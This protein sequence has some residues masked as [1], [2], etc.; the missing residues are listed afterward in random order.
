AHQGPGDHHAK[1]AVEQ[2]CH[3]RQAKGDAIGGQRFRLGGQ[4]PKL[5]GPHGERLEGHGTEGEKQHQDQVD[6]GDAPRPAHTQPAR[7][8]RAFGWAGE[9]HGKG[10]GGN[11]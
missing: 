11:H 6:P 2:G 3:Q 5:P 7:P 10:R 8:K 9:G 1:H 4:M